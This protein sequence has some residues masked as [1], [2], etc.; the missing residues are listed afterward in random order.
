MIFKVN[1]KRTLFKGGDSASGPVIYWMSREQRVR[2]NWALLY[3]QEIAF[4]RKAP[5][6]VAFCLV[7][8][9]LGATMRHYGFMLKGLA[10]VEADLKKLGIPFFLLTGNPPEEIPKFLKKV[11]AGALVSD[12]LPLKISRTWKEE[13]RKATKIS[14]Y[15]VDAHNIVPCWVA[16]GKQE[17]GA[18]T[19]RPKINALLGEY[20][21]EFPDLKRHPFAWN[22]EV[23]K[24]DWARARQTIRVD[25]KIGEVDWIRPG[26]KAGT[27]ALKYFM[28]KRLA[29]YDEG[30]ND[31]S[32][33]GQSELSPYF[34][35]GQ[36][37]PQ[38][39]ALEVKRNFRG[40]S[41][42]AYLEELIIRRELSDNY[43]FYN[44]NYDHFE[45]FPDWAK[46]TLNDHRKDKRPRLYDTEQF[47]KAQT[48]DPYWN[49]AQAQMMRTGK[50][51]G[52]MRMYWA[53]KIL[54]WTPSPEEAQKIAIYLNDKYELDGRDPNGYTG[55]AWSL[56]GVHDRPWTER[57]IF[58]KVRYMNDKGLERK[59]DIKKYAARN[60]ALNE[61]ELFA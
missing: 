21:E 50:M 29:N 7:P 27:A 57:P 17:W 23:S 55:I 9:F 15:V 36:L 26:E 53:K 6:A 28:E 51:H 19:I 37:A 35:F 14:F 25:E 39:A 41:A 31:P 56:G 2:D 11:K 47:E 12:F 54:E 33:A 40:K 10:E 60:G 1:I 46:L 16:S 44:K 8:Q 5:L 61:K 18:Y 13:V 30:R 48:H 43:C 52:Y 49:A 38:R 58:G 3:A 32:E 34:H 24:I 45:G 4:E 59:F 42:E 22:G 20:L